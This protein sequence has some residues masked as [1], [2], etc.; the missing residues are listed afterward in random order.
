MEGH[1][2]TH[3]GQLA[4]FHVVL[5]IKPAA[6]SVTALRPA[7]LGYGCLRR[8][9]NTDLAHLNQGI[10]VYEMR[11]RCKSAAT[12]CDFVD[13]PQQRNG[14]SPMRGSADGRAHVEEL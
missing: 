6:A 8:F 13:F 1:N 2:W 10:R 7:M 3:A 5:H 11:S 12:S 4:E 14:G 9:P